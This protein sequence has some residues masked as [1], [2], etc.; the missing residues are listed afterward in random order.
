MPRIPRMVIDD[1]TTVYHVMSRTALDG[2]PL[3]DIEKDF[4]L[5]LIKRYATLYFVEILGFC[6]MGNHFHIL[7]K[8]LPEYKFSDQ[9]IKKRYVGFYGDERVFADGLIPSLRAKLSSL[10]EFVREIKVGFAR[11]YNKRHNRRGYF[12]GDRFKSVIVDKGETLINCLAY[13]DLNPLRAGIVKRPE[14]YRWNSLGYHVQTNNRDN[15]LSTDFGLKEF[16]VKSEKERIRRY[17]RYVYETGA[18][19]RPEKGK[20]K[21]IGDRILEKERNREFELSRSDRFR[22]RT[23]YFTDSGVIGSKEFVSKT[24]MRFKHV[25]NSKNDKTPKAIKGLSGVYSL[26]RL[27]EVV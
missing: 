2:F 23:R 4:M 20:A 1:E 21:V 27:S 10:S 25:F 7:V 26:K 14:D 16:N 22:Y 12:W 5:D 13:I 6:L 18:V 3:G 19:N 11:Y 24:Y 9:D 15:F 8:T 17:R